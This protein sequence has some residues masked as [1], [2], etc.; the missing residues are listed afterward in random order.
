LGHSALSSTPL[1]ELALPLLRQLREA[2]GYTASLGVLDGADVVV[3]QRSVS[4]R[5]SSRLI[6]ERSVGA[7]LPGYSTSLGKVLLASIPD[8]DWKSRLGSGR[9]RKHGPNT[10]ISR[11]RL[12]GHLREVRERGV[13]TSYE[14]LL[15]D[16]LSIA[17]PVFEEQGEV[18]AAIGLTAHRSA[19]TVDVLARV[20]TA[21]L[22]S[23]A[24]RLSE[25]LG[26]R[27]HDRS[28]AS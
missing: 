25:Q 9:L 23:G 6:P 3:T 22:K 2:T 16:V 11:K 14:E 13:A 27:I 12:A 21:Q 15:P 24:S 1:P 26:Y 18:T 10:I 28:A 19:T 20:A 5:R 17:V 8:G 7:R 4:T